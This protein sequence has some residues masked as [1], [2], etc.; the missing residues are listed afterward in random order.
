[1][2]GDK[3]KGGMALS[4]IIILIIGIIAISYA[5]S[6]EVEIVSAKD[7]EETV[8]FFS[9]PVV[10]D[11]TIKVAGQMPTT[12]KPTFTFTPYEHQR[13]L[14]TTGGGPF[15]AKA[16]LEEE[17]YRVFEGELYLEKNG[18]WFLE[19][20]K[21]GMSL[22][23]VIDKNLIKELKGKTGWQTAKTTSL[24]ILMNAGYAFSIYQGIRYAFGWIGDE[25][26]VDAMSK[27]IGLGFFAGKTSYNLFKTGGVLSEKFGSIGKFLSSEWGG[28]AAGAG[29][30]VVIF[31]ITYKRDAEEIVSFNCKP[32]D[33]Q[34][35]GNK[36]EECNK[37]GDLPCSEYQCRALGQGC[38]IINPGTEEEKCVWINRN[39][40]DP[41]QIEA[42]ENVLLEKYRYNPAGI[43]FP[44]KQ[45]RG[46]EIEYT[47]ST[48]GCV[49]AFSPFSFGIQLNE[50]GKCKLDIIRKQDFEEMGFFF[51]NGLSL[52]NHSFTMSLPGTSA[53]E[54]EGIEVQNDGEYEIY[55]R[56]SDANEN[57]NVGNFVFKYCVQKGPDTTAPV[58][59]TTSILDNTPIAHGESSIDL[60]AYVNEPAQCKWSHDD[61][62]YENMETSMLCNLGL[63]QMNAQMLYKCSTTLEGIKDS[64]ENKFYFRCED[65]ESNENSE[66]TEFTLIGTKPLVI[67]NV[68]PNGTI[69]DSTE[70]IKVSL[71]VETSA[72]YKEGEATCYYKESDESENNY[73][74][75]YETDS[76]E[77][78]QNLWLEEGD[79][80][81]T[82][83]CVDLGGNADEET[84]EFSV[85]S[86][87]EQPIITRAYK[88]DT[89]LKIITNEKAEC[90]Y[91]NID[92][93]YS[94]EEGSDMKVLEEVEHYIEWKS[95]QNYYIKC[96]DEYDNQPNFNECSMIIRPFDVF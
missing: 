56:C 47:D 45:D 8:D 58:I 57:T 81:Y 73:V 92:C 55:V 23:K 93:D 32:W 10:L 6:S 82:I 4:Q 71:E 50:P 87:T 29:V 80:D 36:C 19:T 9:G 28:L 76:Y 37:Q 94:F 78:L 62:S 12:P 83:R 27:S 24:Q 17:G 49:P 26:L 60:D 74:K 30:S 63:F 85:E 86:D 2:R 67:D 91:S 95:N 51:S 18:E 22:E 25:N 53:L 48:T 52:Y 77:H 61:K 16:I 42:F 7:S 5:L 34:T 13:A 88:E 31:L 11:K 43:V 3:K 72:G 20:G 40:I 68:L 54:T 15:G 41:P 46:V 69:K 14:T 65:K 84:L 33:A 59:V 1:M 64:Q 44:N 70:I 75:F 35:K 90:V 79:Y 39:D 38:E 66:S 89:N 21:D 96:K